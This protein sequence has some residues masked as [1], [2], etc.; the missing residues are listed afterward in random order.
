MADYQDNPARQLAAAW[1][2]AA[3]ALGQWREQ[4]TAA[5]T[6]AVEKLDPAMRAAVDAVKSALAGNWGLCQCPCDS[7]HPKDMGVCDGSA[8]LTRRVDD[9]DVPLCA[10]CAVAQGVAEM[11][12]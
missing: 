11:P 2:T 1:Q 6:E 10:P 4:V 12:H 3:A 5:T 8:I 9:A 7:A